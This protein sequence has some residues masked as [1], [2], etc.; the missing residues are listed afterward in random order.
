MTLPK[1][2]T[3]KFGQQTHTLNGLAAHIQNLD[4]SVKSQN[5]PD[6]KTRLNNLENNFK[7]LCQVLGEMQN[8]HKKI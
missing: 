7:K 3:T 1:I 8:F 2:W 5:I 4:N 6:I